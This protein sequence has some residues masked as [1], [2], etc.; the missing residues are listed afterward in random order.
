MDLGT[1][2]YSN[3]SNDLMSNSYSPNYFTSQK[4]PYANNSNLNYYSSEI[5][6]SLYNGQIRL[7]N[8]VKKG[9]LENEISKEEK[10][11]ST[12]LIFYC[13]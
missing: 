8:F 3:S 12:L 10:K 11:S 5:N 7:N 9:N 1:N 13:S 6:N 4:N 2:F